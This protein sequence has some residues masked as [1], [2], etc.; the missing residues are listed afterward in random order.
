M[1]RDR[2]LRVRLTGWLP[3]ID[4]RFLAP[5]LITCIL[6]IGDYKYQV[7]VSYW[8]TVA[9]IVSAI[10]L[11]MLLGRWVT[12]R[13]PHLASAYITGISV[14]ILMRS[15]EWW[16]FVLCSLLSISSK[17][18]LRIGGR[19]LW[20]PSNLGMSVLLFLAPGAAASLSQQWGNDL[21]PL[22]VIW[23]LGGVILF[24]LGRLHITLTYVAAFVALSFVRSA[25]SGAQWINEV[26]PLTQPMYQLYIF[27]MITDP[28]TTPRTWPRQCVVA[29]LVAVVETILRLNEIIYAPYYALF[30]VS[31]L[32]N[33]L[34]IWWT[35][36][37]LPRCD[38]AGVTT[39]P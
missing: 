27:F 9:A 17:Y 31:P 20:N 15:T 16:P 25:V 4:N 38:P 37:K 5:I 21:W 34:E 18:A 12:G 30:I 33:L 19:H 11:E 10:A 39:Q 7:L 36:R 2:R 35:A 24:R 28:A 29:V 6:A 14:G 1:P 32:T 26:A 3:R 13:W 22:L 8:F 23:T